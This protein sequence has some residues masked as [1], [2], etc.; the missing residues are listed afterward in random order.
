MLVAQTHNWPAVEGYDGGWRLT[1]GAWRSTFLQQQ[2]MCPLTKRPGPGPHRNIPHWQAPCLPQPQRRHWR[3]PPH[4]PSPPPSLPPPV[5]PSGGPHHGPGTPWRQSAERLTLVPMRITTCPRHANGAHPIPRLR[6]ALNH[7]N[8]LITG[9]M[10]RPCAPAVQS[11]SSVRLPCPSASLCLNS[12][13]AHRTSR[14]VKHLGPEQSPAD[15]C[16]DSQCALLCK[17]ASVPHCVPGPFLRHRGAGVGGGFGM[18]PWCDDLVCSWRR[19]L[20]DRHS[21]PFPWTLSLHRRW[22]PSASHHPL[23]FLFLLAL[24]F[25]LPS[26]FPSLGLSLCRPPCPSASPH[27]FPSLSLGRLCQRSP[28]TCPHLNIGASCCW[29]DG[30]VPCW[31]EVRRAPCWP[32][33]PGLVRALD[34]VVRPFSG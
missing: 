3:P 19:L 10:G 20:A 24:T 16:T 6:G 30:A 28:R 21:L 31:V 15:L 7:R 14:G 29:V 33:S 18:T 5:T 8:P 11:L 26:P 23:T 34:D 12:R 25:P 27:S 13:F 4:W 17:F 1:D 32:P 2:K 9:V 22:C